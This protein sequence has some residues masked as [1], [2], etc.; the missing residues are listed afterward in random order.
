M[1][2]FAAAEGAS[3]GAGADGQ[4]KCSELWRCASGS[5]WIPWSS[6]TWGGDPSCPVAWSCTSIVVCAAAEGAS[7]QRYSLNEFS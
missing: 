1:V 5:Q 6:N 7:L 2:I 4:G 3:A